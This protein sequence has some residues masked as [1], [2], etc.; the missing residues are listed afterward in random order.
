LFVRSIK[1][2][3]CTS[4]AAKTIADRCIINQT[5][6]NNGDSRTRL[7][8]WNSTYLRLV[9]RQLNEHVQTFGTLGTTL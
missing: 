5:L 7:F 6:N 3:S 9:S 2:G 4:T 1:C 8:R